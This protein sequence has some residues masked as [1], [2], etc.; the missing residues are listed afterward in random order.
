[1]FRAVTAHCSI[2]CT[3]PIEEFRNSTASSIACLSFKPHHGTIEN[4]LTKKMQQLALIYIL[5]N[6]F[7]GLQ[8][9][10]RELN[11]ETAD[12]KSK[13]TF[14]S[15]IVSYVKNTEE[16]KNMKSQVKGEAEHCSTQL[17]TFPINS[18]G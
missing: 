6:A 5:N 2:S 12:W 15:L 8:T 14:L 17:P 10:M 9:T 11:L 1:M 7:W 16:W 3:V 13:F 18:S 4:H